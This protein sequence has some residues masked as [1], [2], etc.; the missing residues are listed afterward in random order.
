MTIHEVINIKSEKSKVTKNMTF[1]ELKVYYANSLEEFNSVM[2]RLNNSML[3]DEKNYI[4]A[5]ASIEYVT[6]DE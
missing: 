3:D 4:C 2:A 5:E 6:D 1:D